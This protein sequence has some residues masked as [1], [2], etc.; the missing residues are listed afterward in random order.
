VELGNRGKRSVGLN[1][2]SPPGRD[3]LYRLAATSDVFLTSF[4]GEARQRLGIDVP[5]IREHNQ[6]I[7]YAR[8]SGQGARGPERDKPGF[9]G[10]SFLARGGVVDAFTAKGSQSPAIGP[11]GFGDLPSGY[12]L[13]GAIAAA[14]LHKERTGTGCVVDVSLLGT[15][16]WQMGI[17]VTGSQFDGFATAG[18]TSRYQAPNP[19][20]ISYQAKDGR[21][22]K[23]SMFQPDRYWDDFCDHMGRPEWRSDPRFKDGAARSAHSAE[24]IAAIEE[25]FLDRTSDEWRE[26]FETLSGAWAMVQSGAELRQDPQ[27]R[28]NGVVG[29][30]TV[31]D[32]STMTVVR[33]PAQFDEEPHELRPAPNHAQ[34]TEEVL[35]ALGLT[36]EELGEL[37][38]RGDIT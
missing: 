7:V 8:G 31:Q 27:A 15:A 18:G 24:C 30:V 21:F 3:L 22:I 1:I 29:E 36:W 16:A 4:L 10:T 33:S 23:L 5:D 26:V 28:H 12:T 17:N 13:A 11:G 35:L 25:A 37:K 14:L 32:G 9:D 6:S 38:E 2:S 19:L 34:D 20:S